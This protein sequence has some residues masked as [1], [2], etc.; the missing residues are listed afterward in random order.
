V[1]DEE[2]D[3]DDEEENWGPRT[4]ANKEEVVGRRSGRRSGRLLEGPA[5]DPGPANGAGLDSRR[6]D[7][8]TP[9]VR[10]RTSTMAAP[11]APATTL[12]QA[13]LATDDAAQA[14][15]ALLAAALRADPHLLPEALSHKAMAQRWTGRIGALLQAKSNDLRL[16]GLRLVAVAAEQAASQIGESLTQWAATVV[17]WLK[18]NDLAALHA[19]VHATVQLVLQRA[20]AIPSLK[21]DMTSAV[22]SKWLQ[23]VTEAAAQ[24]ASQVRL[25]RSA[26]LAVGSAEAHMGPSNP[27]ARVCVAGRRL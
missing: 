3:A 13:F 4:E 19:E 23:I 22:L 10:A 18:R 6:I 21:R 17:S 16:A 8:L 9:A 27:S 12:F 1:Q 15:S 5:S 11:A 24:P 7:L 2:D 26:F 25:G 20:A 14:G